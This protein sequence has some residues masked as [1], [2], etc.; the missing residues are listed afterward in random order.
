[1][2]FYFTFATPLTSLEYQVALNDADQNN[3]AV[4][5]GNIMSLAVYHKA[6]NGFKVAVVYYEPSAT[7]SQNFGFDFVVF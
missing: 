1:M 6:L 2:I 4:P 5:V 7:S 3:N